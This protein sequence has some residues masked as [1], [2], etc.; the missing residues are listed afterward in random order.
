MFLAW[1]RP[2]GCDM[3]AFLQRF[4]MRGVPDCRVSAGMLCLYIFVP[5]VHAC[6]SEYLYQRYGG[7]AAMDIKC[8]E[9]NQPE[10]NERTCHFT[11]WGIPWLLS[12]QH[13]PRTFNRALHLIIESN[14]S[15]SRLISHL[16]LA[17][18]LVYLSTPPRHIMEEDALA[19]Q[20]DELTALDVR[21]PSQLHC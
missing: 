14:R 9:S 1:S 11:P 6:M 13:G 5:K 12:R 16:T 8:G 15:P 21:T 7:Q 20:D 3:S 19:L 17:F 2:A 18:K 4:T 10:P